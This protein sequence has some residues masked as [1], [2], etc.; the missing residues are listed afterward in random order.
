LQAANAYALSS[1]DR[2]M[3]ANL[4]EALTVYTKLWREKMGSC[5]FLSCDDKKI[6]AAAEAF[7]SPLDMRVREAVRAAFD[8]GG[9]SLQDF[10][11]SLRNLVGGIAHGMGSS[12]SACVLGARPDDDMLRLE[13][14]R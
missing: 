6:D 11:P 3:K 8:E 12:Q 5:G 9:I 2:T 7:S 1:C 13:R 4:V 14:R 10:P